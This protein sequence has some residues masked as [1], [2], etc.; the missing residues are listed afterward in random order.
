[1]SNL[2]DGQKHLL[3]LIRKDQNE[4]GWAKVSKVVWPVVIQLPPEL[5]DYEGEPEEGGKARLTGDGNIVLDW[6]L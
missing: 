4:E 3:R 2:T 1:M 5:V 6:L